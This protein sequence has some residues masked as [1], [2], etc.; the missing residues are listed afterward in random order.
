MNLLKEKD[1]SRDCYPSKC[2]RSEEIYK[3][4]KFP[5]V[6]VQIKGDHVETQD[7]DMA[8]ADYYGTDVLIDLITGQVYRGGKCLSSDNLRLV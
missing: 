8:V 2:I 5:K 6:T 4:R 3:F 7:R 1:F